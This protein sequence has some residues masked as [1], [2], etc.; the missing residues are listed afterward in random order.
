M[1]LY[2]KG[3]HMYR[4][5]SLI[6]FLLILISACTSSA[7]TEQPTPTNNGP[8]QTEEV[9][10]PQPEAEI[11]DTTTSETEEPAVE[12]PANNSDSGPS[13]Y[14]PPPDYVNPGVSASP[15]PQP[16]DNQSSEPSSEASESCSL[17]SI[18]SGIT[19]E[20]AE[21]LQITGDLYLPGSVR[22]A[23]YP[24]VILLHMLG[25]DR[26]SWGELPASLASECY[27]VLNMDLRGHGETQG[28]V[29]WDLAGEDIQKAIEFIGS[30]PG[31]SPDKIAIIGA[32]IG[33]N[34]ALNGA[35]EQPQVATVILLSPGLD[36]SGVQTEGALGGYGARPIL[37]VASEEDSYA[38]DSSRTLD[39]T[40]TGE[41]KLIVL[42]N[43]GHGT[44]MLSS[45]LTIE[46]E[47]LDWLE[48]NLK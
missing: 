34:L 8:A 32:S 18:Q 29:N 26:T 38:A 48:T 14:A 27:I 7:P 15:Y 2:L 6:V 17:Y 37:I 10:E 36:Y 45:D 39:N 9:S 24:A 44:D 20:G 12:E 3:K 47:I 46:T 19:F 13:A 4:K 11:P 40:A 42:A 21:G 33:A 23:E 30:A 35:S 22:T 1:K 16:E 41:K 28:D 5:L 31:V 43:A 25:Q